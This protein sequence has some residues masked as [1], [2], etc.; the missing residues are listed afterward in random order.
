VQP[1]QGQ[2]PGIRVIPPL[3]FVAAMA[4]AF[5]ANALWPVPLLPD[6]IRYT[7]G[8]ALIVASGAVMPPTLR[9]FRRAGTPFDVRRSAEALVTDG[10]YRY[11]RNPAYVAM[12][13]LCLGIAI[14]ADNTWAIATLMAATAYLHRY[15]VLAEERHLETRFGADY[16]SYKSRV[17]RW[18]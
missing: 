16:R 17:Q 3:I 9:A 12:I 7:I 11:S 6:V 1:S 15:V 2:T 13:G 10:P 4:L 5:L 18:I 8:P 14:V